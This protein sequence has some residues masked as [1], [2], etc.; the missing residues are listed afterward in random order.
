MKRLIFVGLVSLI[1]LTTLA[2]KDPV[3]MKVD[4]KSVTKSEFEHIFKKNNKDT[5][6]TKEDIDEYLQLFTNFKLKVTEAEHLQM[7]TIPKLK[8]ELQQFREQLAKPYLTDQSSTDD[9]KKEAYERMKWEVRAQHILIK[10]NETASP[11]DTLKAYNKLMKARKE[12]EGGADFG[13]VAQKYS[14]DPSVKQN[15][16]DLGYFSAFK[17]VYPFESGVYNTE[18]GKLSDIVRTR[19]GYHLIKVVDKRPARGTR[20]A[21]HI[22]IQANSK[23]SRE[24]QEQAKKKADE[25]YN[26]LKKGGNFEQL[27]KQHSDDRNSAPEGGK[28]KW[29]TAGDLIPEFDNALFALKANNDFSEPI[30]TQFGY[31]IIKRLD[32]KELGTFEEVE[33][34]IKSKMSRDSRNTIS[35][36]SFIQK[37]KKEYKFKSKQK[38]LKAFEL[39]LDSTLAQGK[40][41]FEGNK[42]A[43]KKLMSFAKKKYTVEDFAKYLENNQRKVRS[44]D[45][46]EIVNKTFKLYVEEEIMNY[47][48]SILESKHEQYRL[49][50][51]EYRD[52]ILLFELTDQMVWK[53]ATKDTSGLKIFYENNKNRFQWDERVDAVFY[54]CQNEKIAKQV[55][56]MRKNGIEKDSIR[57]V[58]NATSPLNVNLKTMKEELKNL[59]YLQG[60]KLKKG[61]NGVYEFNG[62]KVLVEV[63][64]ILPSQPKKLTEAKGLI[65]AAYQD[66]LEEE[67]IKSLKNKY[68]VE[69]M[70]AVYTVK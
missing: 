35:R 36:Q 53:K 65:T 62:Q 45:K 8:R 2:Q 33:S 25:I 56:D 51:K 28:L 20:L 5:E 63:N 27:A 1:T 48:K 60:A 52:G 17:M 22:L 7:D 55:M 59:T 12:V 58:M 6:I 47:E 43:S 70:D 68:E 10:C 9:L 30:K 39:S 11:E 4:G 66:H 44:T 34:E 64:E 19:F 37:L 31:H 54:F 14:E 26:N 40:Y 46:S 49:L 67:W 29:F 16:G 50:M 38:V 21:A 15:S 42:L 13:T 24:Q 69:V 61:M 57:K 41:M 23:S 32:S 3:V 18:K